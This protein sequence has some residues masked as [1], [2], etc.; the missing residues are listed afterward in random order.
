MGELQGKAIIV[1]GAGGGIGGATARLLAELG[2]SVVANDTDAAA[3]KKT[4]AGITA[5][6]GSAISHIADVAD[7][8]EAERLVARCRDSFGTVDGLVNIAGAFVMGRLDEFTKDTLKILLA[9]NVLSAANCAAHALKV[10]Q[11]QGSGSIINVIS[12]AHMG[13]PAMSA[14]GACKGAVASLTYSW[15]NE[16]SG[17]RI[18]VNAVSPM[19]TGTRMAEIGNEFL[20]SK[21]MAPPVS[22]VAA[23]S[24]APVFAYL[25]SD[26][27][28]HINGQIVRIEGE[29]LSLVAHPAVML[30]VLERVGGWTFETV[31]QAFT[32]QLNSRQAPLGVTGVTISGY[33]PP[34][35]MWADAERSAAG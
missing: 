1:T 29:Q 31:R 34:S 6:G 32:E 25:L 24:N 4:V 10:M 23:E 8:D 18:R 11:A 13:L 16:L 14:Y 30:P 21:G 22:Q 2:A 20:R 9:A 7:W 26:A 27:A 33:G 17:S 3:A 15:A 5:A 35:R 12:G 19:A 28:A